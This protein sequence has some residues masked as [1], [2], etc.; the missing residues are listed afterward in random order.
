MP[1]LTPAGR[2]SEHRG[3]EVFVTAVVDADCARAAQAQ[4][5]GDLAGVE[6]IVDVDVATHAGEGSCVV[7]TVPLVLE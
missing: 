7:P 2:W 4:D 6:E 5:L 1:E 3:W